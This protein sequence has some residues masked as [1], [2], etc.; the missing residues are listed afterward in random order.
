MGGQTYEGKAEVKNGVKR[1]IFTVISIIIELAVIAALI[2]FAG[3]KAAWIYTILRI[4]AVV[5]VLYIYSEHNSATIRMTWIILVLLMPI[6]GTLLYLLIGFNGYLNV[7]RKRY[8]EIDKVLLPYL[9]D[10]QKVIKR[11]G[12]RDG[13]LKGLMNHIKNYS[14]YPPY[15]N[16]KLEY[17]ADAEEG[18]EQ[19][20]KDLAKAE[21]FIF[22]E[23]HAI[24]D[25]SAWHEI[26]NVLVDRVKAGVEVRVFYDDMGSLGFINTDFVTRMESLGIQCR[27]FNPFGPGLNLFLNNRDHRKITVI[28]GKVGFTGGYNLAEEYFH[29][30]EPFGYWK[31]TGLRLEGDAVQSLTITFLEMWNAVNKEDRDDKDFSKYIPAAAA[32]RAA[33]KV[34]EETDQKAA[35]EAAKEAVAAEAPVKAPEGAGNLGFVVP[36][37]DSPLDKRRIGEEVYMNIADA[38]QDY[39]WIM[40]PYLILTDEMTLTLSLAAK[41]GVDVRVVT[42]GIPDKKLVYTVTRS[43]YNGL[44]RNGVKVYEYTPGFCHAKMT[45]CDD[46]FATCG[47]IN[48]DYR[49]LY[50]HFENG[51]LYADNE[52]VMATKRDFESVFPQCRDVTEEYTTG[53]NAF[54]RLEQ[55]LLRFFAPLM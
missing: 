22:M 36:Y 4:A 3:Q 6:A 25:A 27:V 5:I 10:N 2:Y 42:P 51:C 29:R 13:R 15:E 53:R 30:T 32:E 11:A 47:T 50:H 20:K 34:W 9:P 48:F 43:Y 21:R 12:M 54:M 17:Y 8:V 55:L 7:M 35:E 41:R 19:Q 44:T 18:F 31:D 14:E 1:M 26:V 28:D 16:T 23:Y 39:L 52:A 24:E 33:A 45:V 38:A 49:S 46:L 37:A 40:T